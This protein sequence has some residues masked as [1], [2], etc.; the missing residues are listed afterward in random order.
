MEKVPLRGGG[1]S[2]AYWQKLLPQDEIAWNSLLYNISYFLRKI[3]VHYGY[4]LLDY[5]EYLIWIGLID[6]Y[7]FFLTTLIISRFFRFD[8]H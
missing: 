7:I 3:V 4:L 6:Q 1:G 2:E 8:L 5:E